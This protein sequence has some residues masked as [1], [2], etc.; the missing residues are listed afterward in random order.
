M[1]FSLLLSREA[2]LPRS[3]PKL[4]PGEGLLSRG[5]AV[6]GRRLVWQLTHALQLKLP[7]DGGP[8]NAKFQASLLALRLQWR[9]SPGKVGTDLAPPSREAEAAVHRPLPTGPVFNC[10]RSRLP[11]SLGGWGPRNPN[12]CLEWRGGTVGAAGGGA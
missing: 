2:S 4:S 10:V 12:V 11:T 7:Q 8:A 3:Q 5:H 6:P 9:H 1:T